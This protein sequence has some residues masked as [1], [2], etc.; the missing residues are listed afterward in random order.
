[1][2]YLDDVRTPIEKEREIVRNYDEFVHALSDV[3]QDTS[4][5][6]SLDHDIWDADEK[7]WYDCA[8][9]LV[10]RIISHN[11]EI[12]GITVHS[13]NPVGVDNIIHY[14]RQYREEKLIPAFLILKAEIPFYI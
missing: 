8:K 13:A 14:F 2:I 5:I 12:E 7:S 3:S 9:R 6:I 1:M 4:L 11:L 10:E